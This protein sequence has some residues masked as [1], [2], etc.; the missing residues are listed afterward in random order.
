MR[1]WK[2]RGTG[3]SDGI[4][5]K[6][7]NSP[8]TTSRRLSCKTS[9]SLDSW[10]SWRPLT[11][12]WWFGAQMSLCNLACI[13]REISRN[14][15]RSTHQT[16]LMPG[17]SK[18]LFW[19]KYFKSR[20]IRL[21]IHPKLTKTISKA[22]PATWIRTETKLTKRLW[23]NLCIS[24]RH[25]LRVKI[26]KHLSVPNSINLKSMNENCTIHSHRFSLEC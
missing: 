20:L 2:T 4:T 12:P 23:K 11:T 9:M 22:H 8:R 15:I 1:A 10:T 3:F 5:I 26:R 14:I 25:L 6:Q 24:G 19:T 7:W 21:I 18:I 17:S 13:W 16:R